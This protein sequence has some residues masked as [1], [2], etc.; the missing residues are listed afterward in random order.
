MP[1]IS[2]ADYIRH[3]F[4]QLMHHNHLSVARDD[5]AREDYRYQRTQDMWV[6]Y[7]SATAM[8]MQLLGELAPLEAENKLLRDVLVK[9]EGHGILVPQAEYEASAADARRWAA[10]EQ[11]GG[12]LTL[13]IHN[14]RPDQRVTVVDAYLEKGVAHG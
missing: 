6:A 12:E 10:V 3:K 8:V 11:G 1:Q 14:S 13:R 2:Q 9:R 4:E 5:S 7:R